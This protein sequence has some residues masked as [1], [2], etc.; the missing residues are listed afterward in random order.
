ML[1]R[2]FL[3]STIWKFSTLNE[4]TEQS[5]FLLCTTST[6][7]TGRVPLCADDD[8]WNAVDNSVFNV[9]FGDVCGRAGTQRERDRRVA[10][11]FLYLEHGK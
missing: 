1:K 3:F 4:T 8:D 9:T 7:C 6:S 11:C 5:N 10:I 2:F